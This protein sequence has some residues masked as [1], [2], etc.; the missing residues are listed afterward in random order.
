M[1]IKITTTAL[2][3]CLAATLPAHS[4]EYLSPNG[5]SGLGLVP[6]AGVLSTGV[7]VLNY[8]TA[9]PGASN[10]AGYNNQIG[11][12]LFDNLELVG[13]LATNDLRCNM[14]RAGAC[15]KDN[16]RDFSASMK[17][18]LPIDWLKNNNAKVAFGV[19]DVGG[20][21]SY[22]KSYYVVASKSFDNIDLTLGRAK[23]KADHAILDGN[24]GAATWNVNSWSQLSLQRI[25]GDSWA[26]AAVSVPIL[27]TGMSAWFN[28]NRRLS[29]SPLTEKQWTGFGISIPLDRVEKTRQANSPAPSRAVARIDETEL[30][31]ALKKNGFY[32]PKI[33][34]TPSGKVIIELEN[35]S[36]QWNILD[37][38]G[39]ALGLIAG[40]HAD[41]QR[42]FDL[43]VSTRGIKQLLIRS[44]AKCVK[45][46]LE[47]DEW[48]EKFEIKSLNNK[49]YD[50]VD[51]TWDAGA[52]WQFRPELI[53]TPT[54]VSPIATEYG[55]FDIDLG[56]NVNTVLPLWRG[57]YWDFNHIYPLDYR[58]TNFEQ[59]GP[60]YASR[61]K[62]VASRRMLHQLLSFP[63]V[64]TQA[65]LSAGMAYNVWDGA[66]VETS[67][68]SNNGRHK[69][70]LTAGSFKTD[71]LK[72]N[73]EKSYHLLNYRYV[74]D[75]AQ[76]TSTELTNGKFWGGDNG[77]LIG[78]RFWHG[79]T[80]LMLYI[81]R[82]RLTEADP[83]VSFAGIQFSIPLTPRKNTG[84]EYFSVRGGSQWTYTIESRI[85]D[86][87]NRIT[88]GPGE[89]PKIGDP[90]VQT[91]NR[92]R[93]TT[94][95]YESN[96]G[97][98][99]NAFANHQPE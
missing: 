8:D 30:V 92:D 23:A 81:K 71:T 82:S 4:A 80:A 94:Q 58:T 57:A 90:L 29:D 17:Y 79:D 78:Q 75:D 76:K 15:P 20:A 98:I 48:C 88:V 11:F 24:F 47:E 50:A 25:G 84:M 96:I 65:R 62:S 56:V 36:Y 10:P 35:T 5:Y 59:G 99:K 41:A 42:D 16:I 46:W 18:S 51:V 45:K 27:D 55:V 7:A 68:Q 13:R 33:G 44:N 63:V 91:F 9:L 31:D 37:A 6:S 54:L 40:A 53:L 74:W 52:S 39:V 72:V 67:T 49:G 64:N 1:T 32:N 61:L 26:N 14:F 70:G 3:L 38:A 85:F 34:K 66:Q 89:I 69:V 87:D 77:Y 21:A 93:N 22:F 83:L 86:K 73:N 12:G 43:I 2:W 97:R 28:Y 95:Y 60:F 19:N